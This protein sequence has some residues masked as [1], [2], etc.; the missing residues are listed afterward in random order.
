[1]N[2]KDTEQKGEDDDS[3]QR[4]M[5]PLCGSCIEVYAYIA[6]PKPPSSRGNID[7]DEAFVNDK[8]KDS[9]Q[10]EC[11]HHTLSSHVTANSQ[12]CILGVY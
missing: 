3:D 11:F 6:N 12:I 1:M 2:E 7:I 9:R 5:S 4:P 8:G 10:Y